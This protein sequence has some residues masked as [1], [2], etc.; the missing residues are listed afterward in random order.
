MLIEE[1]CSE[2]GHKFKYD[3]EFYVRRRFP[4]PKRC[5]KCANA[6]R[7]RDLGN[8]SHKR[9]LY[10]PKVT[11]LIPDEYIQDYEMLK[12][13]DGRNGKEYITCYKFKIA[14]SDIKGFKSYGYVTCYDYRTN[15]NN[16][17][18]CIYGEDG[19]RDCDSN[20]ASVRVMKAKNGT[21]SYQYIV[22]DD[23]EDGEDGIILTVEQKPVPEAIWSF[24]GYAKDPYINDQ[25][26]WTIIRKEVQS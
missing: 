2:C 15:I 14:M 3:D 5:K 22:L 20:K 19:D 26:W 8:N 24:C 11:I 23:V 21:S 6:Y 4:P 16:E 9:I 17:V 7:H 18:L 1:T 10:E 25:E 13:I 12:R